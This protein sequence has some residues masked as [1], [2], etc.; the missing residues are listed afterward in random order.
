MLVFYTLIF[1]TQV[2]ILHALQEP[3][4]RAIFDYVIRCQNIEPLF[5]C[6]HDRHLIRNMARAGHKPSY[7]EVNETMSQVSK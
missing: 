5:E 4:P 6:L 7:S 3:V 2:V 1:K